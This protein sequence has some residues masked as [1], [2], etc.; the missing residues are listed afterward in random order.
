MNLHMTAPSLEHA[1]LLRHRSAARS[2]L[3]CLQCPYCGSALQM[4]LGT[5]D[6]NA[7]ENDAAY[8]VFRCGCSEYPIVHGIPILQHIEGLET[9]TAL[10]RSRRFHE[11]LKLTLVVFRM[12]WAHRTVV[13]RFRYERMC[14]KLVSSN[15]ACFEEA[16]RWIR[17]PQTFADYLFHRYA[18]PSFLASIAP[19]MSLADLSTCRPGALVLDMGCG[20]GHSSFLMG[21]LFPNLEVVCA[22]QDFSNVYLS[23]RFMSP[24]R[25][26]LC[27]DAELPSPLPDRCIDALFCLDSFHYMKCKR[28][29]VTELKRIT[30]TNSYWLFPH[31]HNALQEN[32][33]AGIP[34]T[35]EAYLDCFAGLGARL[36]TEKN[37]LHALA[38]NHVAELDAP[39][40]TSEVEAAGV[41]TLVAG[42]EGLWR[43]HRGFPERLLNTGRGLVI[44][45]IYKRMAIGD[46]V[47]FSFCW[48]NSTMKAECADAQ[49]VMPDS[50]RISR[51]KL[52]ALIAGR[53]V[54]HSYLSELVSKFVLVSLPTNYTN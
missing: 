34:L 40:Q 13:Q 6:S 14:G 26:H 23:Q 31:L 45:P 28:L 46:D 37:L 2:L 10:I 8:G 35:P 33:T 7:H 20:A 54:D 25:L 22:D 50:Y 32:I 53:N 47:L 43:K 17:Q 16:V 30:H 12:K 15:S 41:L 18:N 48:P 36:F 27:I 42:P 24:N 3:Q 44:N 29:F 38:N 19:I 1:E 5:G 39:A 52:E 51:H 49:M 21:Q 9:V 11:A 4:V